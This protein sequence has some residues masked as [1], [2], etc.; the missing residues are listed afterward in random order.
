MMCAP[1]LSNAVLYS[2]ANH[3]CSSPS[4]IDDRNM[5]RLLCVL[6]QRRECK[7]FITLYNCSTWAQVKRF[8]VSTMDAADISWSPDGTCL[9][10]WDSLLT[11]KVLVYNTEGACQGSYSAYN[12]ALG[13]RTVTWSPGG[14]VLAVGS[15]DQVRVTT[16]EGDGAHAMNLCVCAC[17][18]VSTA[19]D[20]Y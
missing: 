7:D 3:P 19:P 5:Y 14:D 8:Q 16:A 12:D 1:V 6:L 15:Y 4:S 10:V 17:Q 11:Y 2:S 20:I 9:A 18:T 13:V